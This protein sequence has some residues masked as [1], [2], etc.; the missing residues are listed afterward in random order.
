M[1]LKDLALALA[2]AVLAMVLNVAMSF[3]WVWIYSLIE[4]GQ[5]EAAYTAYAQQW[6]PVSSVVFGAPILF[7]AGWI[8][9]RG[10]Q[11][12]EATVIGW[13]IAGLYV[14]I[15]LAILVAAEIPVGGWMWPAISW[16]TKF[17]FAEFG[18]R[19]GARMRPAREPTEPSTPSP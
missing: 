3:I 9:G 6:A 14:A 1:K 17:I 18:A 16:I 13:V 11:P 4:P 10:R 19:M 2:L 8:A 12:L 7:A 5:T 15:D